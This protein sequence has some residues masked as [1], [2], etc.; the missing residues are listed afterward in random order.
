MNKYDEM[1]T[2]LQLILNKASNGM[3][4]KNEYRKGCDIINELVF[5]KEKEENYIDMNVIDLC[6][7]KQDY[8][9]ECERLAAIL[10][11]VSHERD[12]LEKQ[13]HRTQLS[14]E[15]CRGKLRGIK[16]LLE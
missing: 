2:S 15:F 6:N 13:L 3:W 4:S 8:K 1:I 7:T 11:D 12:E 10:E 14:L 5:M 9:S 16:K